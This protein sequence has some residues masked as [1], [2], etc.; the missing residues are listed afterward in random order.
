MDNKALA[1]FLSQTS[2]PYCQTRWRMYLQSYDFDI[3]NRP[4]K[5]NVLAD[6]LSSV[7]AE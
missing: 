3:I 7:Y 1:F 2:L 6:V 4:G 5:D